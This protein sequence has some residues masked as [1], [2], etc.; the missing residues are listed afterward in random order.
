MTHGSLGRRLDKLAAAREIGHVRRFVA[1]AAAAGRPAPAP[2]SAAT[3]DELEARIAAGYGLTRQEV[4]RLIAED[5]AAF[6]R[7]GR[8][9]DLCLARLAPRHDGGAR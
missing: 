2:D 3:D 8:F 1:E 4:R 7:G 6:R 5:A 9:G